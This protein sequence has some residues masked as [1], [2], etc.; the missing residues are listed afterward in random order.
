MMKFF[1]VLFDLDGTLLDTIPDLALAC[2]AMRADLGLSALPQEH[3]TTLVG[4]GTEN[5]VRR[6]L[7]DTSKTAA[8]IAQ[9]LDLFHHH[10]SLCNGQHSRLYP[11]VLEG[12]QDFQQQGLRL[13]VV[14][15]K[16]ERFARPLLE[17]TGLDAY[18]ELLVGGDTCARKKPDPLPFLHACEQ[19]GTDPSQTLVVGDSLNDAQAARAA[20]IPVL[21]VPYGYNE[22]QDVQSLESDGIVDSIACAARWVRQANNN[23]ATT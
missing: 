6:A 7:S 11:G 5:L 21:L 19:L 12:L 13:A 16:P 15:N 14:T 10:Y 2:N 4:K 17:H 22:G 8:D 23:T 20:R 3:V 1:S 9:A 18:F